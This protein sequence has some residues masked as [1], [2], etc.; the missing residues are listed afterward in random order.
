[1][2]PTGGSQGAAP[3]VPRGRPEP[4]KHPPGEQLSTAGEGAGAGIGLQGLRQEPGAALSSSS[5]PRAGEG[6][7][8]PCRH[9][10]AARGAAL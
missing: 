7:G 8:G 9:R 5:Q 4:P 1:M 10:P 3:A 2:P 6:P